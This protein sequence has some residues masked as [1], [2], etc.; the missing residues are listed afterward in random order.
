M[1]EN[2]V[3]TLIEDDLAE[4][5]VIQAFLKIHRALFKVACDEGIWGPA[6]QT[7]SE[8]R[9]I[10]EPHVERINEEKRKK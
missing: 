2:E 5:A 10:F 7:L 6:N 3:K 1:T 4:E 8:V 9:K